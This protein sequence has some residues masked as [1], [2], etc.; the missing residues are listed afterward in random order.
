[1]RA[2]DRL[3]LDVEK[4][5]ACTEEGRDSKRMSR[6]SLVTIEIQERDQQAEEEQLQNIPLEATSSIQ[7]SMSLGGI[8]GAK[9][10]VAVSKS[11]Q[12]P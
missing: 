5:Y 3:V 4:P 6:F 9:S 2:I 7:S 12:F 1:M 11:S 8:T 10:R